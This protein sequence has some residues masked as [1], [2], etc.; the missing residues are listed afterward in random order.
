MVQK[1]QSRAS[2]TNAGAYD[3]LE[4]FVT[5]MIIQVR[6]RTTCQ[7]TQLH[8]PGSWEGF[9]S[10]R[11]RFVGPPYVPELRYSQLNRQLMA[12]DGQ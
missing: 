7:V 6:F 4:R 3:T 5:A 8:P 12:I 1:V 10:D 11:L 2:C 9:V